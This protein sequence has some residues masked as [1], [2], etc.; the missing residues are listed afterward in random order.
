MAEWLE[1]FVELLAHRAADFKYKCEIA[2]TAG[3]L[4]QAGKTIGH[5]RTAEAGLPGPAGHILLRIGLT[6]LRR[7]ALQLLCPA[8]RIRREEDLGEAFRPSAV[9]RT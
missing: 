9:E 2:L 8:L 4:L 6:D 3:L 7:K 5:A 1:E